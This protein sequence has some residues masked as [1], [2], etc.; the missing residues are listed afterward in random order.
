VAHTEVKL[1]VSGPYVVEVNLRPAGNSITELVR[2]VTGVDVPAAHVALAVGDE[3][4]LTPVPTAVGGAA[5]R[6]V[7]PQRT[8]RVVE[9]RGG[10]PPTGAPD[11]VDWH[12]D[13]LAGRQI[14]A[15]GDNNG[16]V[17][18]VMVVA[19]DAAAAA[20]RAVELCSSIELVY[21]DD[22]A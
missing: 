14:A 7:V 20:A 21:A 6:F 5:I 15:A 11:V 10:R 13:D 18:R 9:V 1:T 17:G 22:D 19:D 8:G 3:P 16:Y 12:V 2:R 4:A